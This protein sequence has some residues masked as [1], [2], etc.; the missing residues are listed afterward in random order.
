[1][2]E[3]FVDTE[4]G[5]LDALNHAL[6]QIGGHDP[7]SGSR[8]N[9]HIRKPDHLDVTPEASKVNGWPHS[10]EGRL[11]RPEAEAIKMFLEWLALVKGEVIVAHNAAFDARFLFAALS[12]AQLPME[13][14]PRFG[15]TQEQ[16]RQLR[17]IGGLPVRSLSLTSILKDLVPTYTRPDVHDAAEDAYA[18][19]LARMAMDARFDRLG[20]LANQNIITPMLQQPRT[21]RR[22]FG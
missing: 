7:Q 19:Y 12:R 16:A 5:G 11:Q 6:L 13:A 10:H 9:V 14:L 2:K 3:V 18:C 20:E 8:F 21:K 4:T 22:K 15:C 17:R 1:L